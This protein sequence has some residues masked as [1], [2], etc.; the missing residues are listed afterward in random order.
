MR[1]PVSSIKK[2]NERKTALSIIEDF[3]Q[4]DK[5]EV[6]PCTQGNMED[7]ILGIIVKGVTGLK[8]YVSL[9]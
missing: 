3:V 5:N 4:F 9:R 6:D 2:E 1:E 8:I 7:F